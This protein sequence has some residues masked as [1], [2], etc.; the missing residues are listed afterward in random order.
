MKKTKGIITTIRKGII[1]YHEIDG[2]EIKIKEG[3][4]TFLHRDHTPGGG[5]IKRPDKFAKWIITERK[6]GMSVCT[7]STQVS[8]IQQATKIFNDY[9]LKDLKHLIDMQIKR[10][11]INIPSDI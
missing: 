3:I 2:Y 7:C 5:F 10:N 8:A 11:Y 1:S 6:S 4:E 9:S